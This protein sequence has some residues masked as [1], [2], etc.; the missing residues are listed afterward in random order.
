MEAIEP[1]LVKIEEDS[2]TPQ[3][4]R[5]VVDN[6]FEALVKVIKKDS[7][8]GQTVLNKNAKYRIWNETE[9]K[10]VEYTLKYPNKVTYGTEENPYQ[11]NEKGEFITPL[12]LQI[13]EYELREVGAP[14]G[15]VKTGYE[16]KM[17]K[18][19]YK[20]EAKEAVKFSVKSNTV[21]Y[22]DAET[23]EII[24][25]VEQYNDEMLGELEYIVKTIKEQ[26]YVKKT[27]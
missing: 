4:Q 12:K 7:Q 8:T 9:K 2:R 15:Y 3:N 5:V 24:I 18:G 26:N 14:E 23:K 21:H 19:E 20:T 27:N 10:Y 6:E 22:E 11:T 17:E 25:E 13:G 1:F 16:G